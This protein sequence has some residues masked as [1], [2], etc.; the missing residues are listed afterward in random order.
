MVDRY[1]T[2][3]DVNFIKNSSERCVVGIR[4]LSE[5][6]SE[7]NHMDEVGLKLNF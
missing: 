7:M 1:L 2:S 3:F 4:L 5:L 6:V